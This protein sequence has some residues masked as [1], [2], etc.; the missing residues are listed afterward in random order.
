MRTLAQRNDMAL[1]GSSNYPAGVTDRTIDQHFG[2]EDT[3]T[4]SECEGAKVVPCNECK[5]EGKHPETLCKYCE[6][7]TERCDECKGEG[8]VH[9]KSKAE[10]R[11][12]WEE[13]KA[14][15]ERDERGRD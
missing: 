9:V 7:G 4:C 10:L 1:G 11:A 5:G 14:D 2:G 6:D 3:E 13:D 15:E 8:E 12:D